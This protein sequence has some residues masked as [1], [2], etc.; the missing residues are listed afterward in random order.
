MVG[1]KADGLG[2][3]AEVVQAKRPRVPDQHPENAAAA[4]SS[5][6]DSCVSASMPCVTK[7]SRAVPAGSITPRAAYFAPVTRAAAAVIR[8]STASSESSELIAMPVSTSVRRR[9]VS[10][11]AAT[12]PIVSEGSRS[13]V[14]RNR[15]RS[16]PRRRRASADGGA[17]PGGLTSKRPRNHHKGLE[18]DMSTITADNRVA[19]ATRDEERPGSEALRVGRLCRRRDPGRFRR[20]RDHHGL[21][22][23]F[24]GC[25]QPQAGEDR[26]FGRHDSRTD[27]QRS[28]GRR[29]DERRHSDRRTSPG[30]AINNGTRARA[31]ASYMRI[32]AL[33]ASGGYTYAQMGRF[34]AKPDAPKAE[35]AVGGGTDNPQWALIGHSDEAAGCQRRPQPLGDR[36]RAD[37]RAEHVLYG[38]QARTVR[39]RR[40]SR[41][42][43]ERDR[44]HRS[45]LRSAAPEVDRRARA[46]RGTRWAGARCVPSRRRSTHSPHQPA[47]CCFRGRLVSCVESDE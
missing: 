2:T 23:P 43:P 20:C 44:L 1:R 29:I 33:E 31:F 22:R 21:Q 38:R 4:G 30:K 41:T 28:E 35:L 27:R 15:A 16:S 9:S 42:A 26:R 24:N 6:I 46:S 3:L 47:P 19:K 25:R 32:H 5:P 34:Q 8:S 45:R 40:R 39:D 12:S 11:G 10:S 13:V 36:D 17:K 7:R 14:S 37:D 18:A